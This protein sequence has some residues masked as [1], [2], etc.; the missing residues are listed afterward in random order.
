M[1]TVRS[2]QHGD[3]AVLKSMLDRLGVVEII[4][5][6]VTES[7]RGL[8]VGTT[9]ALSALNRAARPRSKRAW[10]EWATET[11]LPHLF[12]LSHPERLT[13]QYFWD[14]MNL[15]SEEAMEAIER[16]L[17]RKVVET[18]D[19]NLDTLL[20]DATNFFTYI[21]SDNLRTELPQR[22]HSKQKRTDLRIFS[23]AMLVS[24]DGQIPLCTHVYKGNTVDSKEFP[25]FLTLMG[26]RLRDTVG[27]DVKDITVVYD[28]GNL[29][30]RNQAMV[31]EAQFHYV[32]SL[33]LSQHE[34]LASLPRAAYKAL[35]KTSRL[36]G[37]R[38]YRCRKSIWGAERTVVLAFSDTLRD[39]QQR[40][41]EQHLGKRIKKLCAWKEQLAKRGSGPRTNDAAANQVKMLGSG[42][43]VKDVLE[44]TYNPR[45]KGANRLT[46]SINQDKMQHLST[47]VF[48]KM[49]LITD[50]HDWSTED[51]VSSYR[52]QS[53][54]ERVFRQEK[55]PEHLAVRPQHHWTDQKI[56]VHTL[57]CTI[58]LTLSR[59]VEREASRLT[60]WK[61]SLS[62]LLT[63]LSKVRL[64]MVIRGGVSPACNWAIENRGESDKA[65]ILFRTLVPTQKPF[66][67][68]HEVGS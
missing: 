57:I 15:V 12:G 55:D 40:G 22:G 66:V 24:R 33:P 56:R 67:Y 46:W 19:I 52:G 9:L 3:V 49:I 26:K 14:Q 60:S 68:T 62:G 63:D 35:P 7:R 53:Y 18:F 20:Y 2:Y 11:S 64:A 38:V 29:S 37:L 34:E 32:T 4:D 59:L 31:D 51:I 54:I 13:S 61:G 17:T 1:M 5:R 21:A 16:D 28:K 43:Y 58:A 36:A 48:G 30:K 27:Q 65:M 8:S 45:R 41:L 10:A 6:H 47:E 50:Q 44:V 39:G 23:L 25:T 42:Q